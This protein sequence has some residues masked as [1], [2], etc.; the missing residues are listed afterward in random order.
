LRRISTSFGKIIPGDILQFD[1]GQATLR[2][3]VFNVDYVIKAS[4]ELY[5]PEKQDHMSED[6]R[7]WYTGI[8]FTWNFNIVVPGMSATKFE[9]TLG[10]KPAQLFN[11]A[12][13]RSE[14]NGAEFSP[15]QA[16]GAM[17]D[18]AFDDFGSKLLTELSVK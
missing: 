12:Y 16:Y 14:S 6:N 9:F 8:S 15:V 5:Y 11:V 3:C 4:G 18:S 10:S 13:E 17:A 1:E 2:D 7:D